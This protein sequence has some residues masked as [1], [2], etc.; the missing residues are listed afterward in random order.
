MPEPGGS[1]GQLFAALGATCIDDGAATARFHAY[2]KTV[3]ALAAGNGRLEGAFHG[4]PEKRAAGGQM[5]QR[6]L[7]E[8]VLPIIRVA[9]A[10]RVENS[11]NSPPFHQ[12]FSVSSNA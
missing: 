1:D 5:Q 10:S 7:A 6:V 3:G 2:A 8:Q 11:V 9:W 4:F 12:I